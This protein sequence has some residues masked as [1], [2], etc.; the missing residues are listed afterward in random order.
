MSSDELFSL[1]EERTKMLLRRGLNAEGVEW[2]KC[3]NVDCGRELGTGPRW[4]VCKE[5]GC[6]KECT[7]TIHQAWEQGRKDAGD[8]AR[9]DGKETV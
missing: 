6:E 5:D 7:D 8:D 1:G 2:T 4:W 9:V 3:S